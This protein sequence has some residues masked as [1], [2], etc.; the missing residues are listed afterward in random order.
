MLWRVNLLT[1]NY[2]SGYIVIH[3][4]SIHPMEL[5]TNLI[6]NAVFEPQNKLPN[7]NTRVFAACILFPLGMAGS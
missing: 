4:A 1:I 2:A 6:E 5:R 7:T 3:G